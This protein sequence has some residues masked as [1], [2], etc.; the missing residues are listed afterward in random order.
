MSVEKRE[1]SLTQL[2]RCCILKELLSNANHL[3]TKVPIECVNMNTSQWGFFLFLN[4]P[5]QC[6]NDS[7]SDY[8]SVS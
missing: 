3:L 1:I 6:K 2:H 4:E 7:G 8:A 5:Q